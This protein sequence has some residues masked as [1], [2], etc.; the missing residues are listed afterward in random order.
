M[1]QRVFGAGALVVVARFQITSVM[2]EN[3]QQTEL[4]HAFAQSWLGMSTMIA[5]QQASKTQRALHGV[6]QI[7]VTRVDGLVIIVFAAEES[8]TQENA[9]DTK[10][11]SPSGN[12]PE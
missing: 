1:N 7:M 2:K 10:L 11:E 3:C 9:L 6:F 4:R 12:I 8:N 5:L